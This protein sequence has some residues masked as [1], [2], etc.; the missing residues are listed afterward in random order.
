MI[1]VAP[2]AVLVGDVTVEEG[3]SIWHG[4]VLRGDFDSIVVGRDSNVQDNAVVHVDRGLPAVLGRRV[5]VG[6]AAV[7]HGC[8]IRDDCL[9]G[10]NSTI[11]SGA[12]IGS[13]SVV[14]S[15]AVVR[16]NAEFPAGGLIA[17]VPAKIIRSVDETLRRRI[18]LSW[19]IYRELAKASLTA[20]APIK[21][22]PS[23]QVSLGLSAEF[24]R[25][26]REE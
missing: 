26:V 16:E 23:K 7:V 24:T 20:R 18:D 19:P 13:G 3:A 11:N 5:T 8:S 2:S 15:G 21:G 10:M 1:Y 14:A 22:D 25:L 17:G 9:I 4:A 6:H 12:V